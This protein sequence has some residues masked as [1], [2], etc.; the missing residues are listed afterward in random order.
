MDIARLTRMQDRLNEHQAAVL[1]AADY[2][3]PLPAPS[4][5]RR[6]KRALGWKVMRARYRLAEFISPE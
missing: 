1:V 3:G 5:R 2:Y 6:F 4:R